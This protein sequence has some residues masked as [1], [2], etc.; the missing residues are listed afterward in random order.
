[1]S[2]M[3]MELRWQRYKERIVEAPEIMKRFDALPKPV[4]R[5][6][7]SIPLDVDFAARAQLTRR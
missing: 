2:K 1:M 7:N 5:A 3:D 6:L 4:R